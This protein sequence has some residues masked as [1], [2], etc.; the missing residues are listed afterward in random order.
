VDRPDTLVR[1]TTG[2]ERSLAGGAKVAYDARGRHVAT[3]SR[4][5]YETSFGYDAQGRLETVSVPPATSGLSYRFI[6]GADGFL[7]RVEAPGVQGTRDV[8]LTRTGDELSIRDPDLTKVVFTYADG[9][10]RRIVARRDR[11]GYTTRF[12]YDDGG[13]VAASRLDTAG[14]VT[15]LSALESVGLAT[16]T[17]G[18]AVDTAQAY[19]LLDG[20]R[21]DSD[22]LDHTRLW[23]DRWGSPR[24]IVNAVGDTTLLTRGDARFPALVTQT[25]SPGGLVTRAWYDAR[26]NVDSTRVEN[27]YGAS[28]NPAAQR[29]DAVTSYVW[30][31]RW[32]AVKEIRLPEGEITRFEYDGNGNRIWQQV[33]EDP[34]R[35]VYFTYETSAASNGL[36]STVT[37]PGL[38]RPDSVAYDALGNVRL[39]VSPEGVRTEYWKDAL[40]RDTLVLAQIDRPGIPPAGGGLPLDSARAQSQ[41]IWYRASTDLVERTVSR[42]PA[43]NVAPTQSLV[44]ESGYDDEGLLLHVSRRSDPD[45]ARIGVVTNRYRY[46]AAGRRVAEV[47]PHAPSEVPKVDSTVYDAAGN[48][49]AVHTRRHDP[50]S[51]GER[52]VV[53]MTYDALGRLKTR[54]LPPVTY[55]AKTIGIAQHRPSRPGTDVPQD[56]PPYPMYPTPGITGYSIGAANEVFDYDITGGIKQAD[57]ADA[58][59]RRTYYPNGQIATEIQRIR[60]V[61]GGFGSHDYQIE[62]RY[63]LNGRR[64]GVR[65]PA[66]LGPARSGDEW[67]TYGYDALGQLDTVADALNHRFTFTYTLRGDLDTLTRP[68]GIRERFVVSADGLATV[69]AVWNT[70]S[71]YLRNATFRYDGRGKILSTVNTDGTRDILTARYSGLGHLVSGSLES[72]GFRSEQHPVRYRSL[73]TNTWDAMGNRVLAVVRDTTVEVG[74]TQASDRSS[75]FRYQAGTGRLR[76][77]GTGDRDTLYYDAAGN[78]EIKASLTAKGEDRYSYYGS[79]GKLRA[80]DHR[81]S[82]GTGTS[83]SDALNTTFE[84]YWYDA[85]GRRVL[86]R[87]RR[88]CQNVTLFPEECRLDKVRRTVWDGDQE[89]YEIQAPDGPY[90]EEDGQ[91]PELPLTGSP[92]FDPN[93]FFGRV[94]YTHG[95]RLDQPLGILRSGY[96]DRLTGPQ[97]PAPTWTPPPFAIFP[98]WTLRG[99]PEFAAYASGA[100]VRCDTVD[101]VPRCVRGYWPGH[102]FTTE[103]P[104]VRRNAWHGTLVEDKRDEAGTFYRRNRYLDPLSGRFTQEDP[105]GLAGGINLYGFAEGD[106]VTYSDPYGLCAKDKDGREDPDCRRVITMLRAVAAEAERSMPA[107]TKSHFTAAAD[108]YERTN[109]GVEFVHSHDRRLNPKR[110]NF[111]GK[112][113]TFALGRTMPNGG[114]ILLN[115]ALGAGDLAATATHEAVVHEHERGRAMT[116]D[117]FSQA[118]DMEIWLQLPNRLEPSAE[119]WRRRVSP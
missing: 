26:G 77:S 84:E 109:R 100:L 35:R 54:T 24:R 114:P 98:L 86:V 20:P 30:D 62:Y 97:T 81:V 76:A 61:T 36:F 102:W 33:G 111:D 71:E 19:A 47:A 70:Q 93:P 78:L 14:I 75:E 108:I 96:T 99:E 104:K 80:A 51:P 12:E 90:A 106:A 17:G 110:E 119:L 27:P 48:P 11:R 88:N 2:F 25:Q 22:V 53:A 107:G 7:Q 82:G 45:T 1:T 91:I 34:A 6:Y 58:Q 31:A 9:T 21:P 113:N 8:I 16:A 44:V 4:I 101:G 87:A 3:R 116:G 72:H 117:L 57:N 50:S 63:D 49:L 67:T 23:L 46:D 115:S 28:C 74:R 55:P 5:G 92:P 79:D 39:R 13:K 94:G 69:N 56:N 85:L 32:D 42:G 41:R 65:H 73:E 10:R 112:P 18:G 40:G 43:M 64:K 118:T 66:Q 60:T 89:F 59:V 38:A 15:R 83:T 29:C 52:L 37:E 105:I 95:L 103:R 68:G